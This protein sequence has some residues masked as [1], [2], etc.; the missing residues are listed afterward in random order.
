MFLCQ[1]NTRHNNNWVSCPPPPG[2]L[3]D[4]GSNPH[5]LLGKWILYQS[6]LGTIPPASTP[7]NATIT[8]YCPLDTNPHSLNKPC[9]LLT[10][11]L[12]MICQSHLLPLPIGHIP[13]PHQT[14]ACPLNPP[15][16]GSPSPTSPRHTPTHLP[17]PVTTSVK[18]QGRVN[19]C[20]SHSAVPTSLT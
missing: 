19:L 20:T 13:W 8:H 17:K 14:S 1:R 10:A 2:Y 11:W 15:G 3:P 9:D 16:L 4:Q 18:L 7:T 12:R 5:L 6:Y